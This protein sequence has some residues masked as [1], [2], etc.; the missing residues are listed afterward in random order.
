MGMQEPVGLQEQVVRE[1]V[2]VLNE[3]TREPVDLDPGI[4][5]FM[6]VR[7]PM[8]Q[9]GV[10]PIFFIANLGKTQKNFQLFD[11]RHYP[12]C[13]IHRYPQILLMTTSEK[14]AEQPP[15]RLP[16][17][18]PQ[19]PSKKLLASRKAIAIATLS[20]NSTPGDNSLAEEDTEPE[21]LS[22]P[23]KRLKK[24][25]KSVSPPTQTPTAHAPGAPARQQPS[26]LRLP[27][28]APSIAKVSH[29]TVTAASKSLARTSSAASEVISIDSDAESNEPVKADLDAELGKHIYTIDE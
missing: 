4:L 21:D 1:Q 6:E 20:N 17:S 29:M 5:P 22:P 16:S 2:W 24:Q 10:H 28:K 8:H 27:P 25:A 13:T 23:W 7:S 26:A 14:V 15:G 9:K 18:R 3:Q 12:L 19:K 11:S